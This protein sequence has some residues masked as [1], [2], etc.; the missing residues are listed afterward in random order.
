MSTKSRVLSGRRKIFSDYE[1]ITAENVVDML[2][3]ALLIHRVN[4]NEIDY[5]YKYYKGI[6]PVLERKKDVRPEICNKIIENHA[7]EIVS[8]K[9]GY[10]MGE[11]IQYISHGADDVSDEINALNE[12]VFAEDK[13]CKDRELADW[14]TICGTAFRMILPD[15]KNEMDESPFEIYTLD[16]RNT[17]VVYWSGLGNKAVAAVTFIEKQDNNVVYCVYTQGEYFEIENDIITK[18]TLHELEFIPIIEYPANEARL[19]AFEPVIP[20][21]DAI[22]EVESNRLDGVEQFIQAILLLKGTGIEDAQADE[23]LFSLGLKLPVDGDAKYLVQE[24]NQT[25]TQTLVDSMYQQV[26]IICGMPN[27]NG[28]SSTS[29]TGAAVIMRDGWEAAE[30]RAKSSE[31][32]FKKSEKEF[33]KIALKISNTFRDINLKLSQIEIRFTR[34]N[35]ENIS[36]KSSVLISM[37]SSDKIHPKLA[38]SHCGMFAD[39][40]SAYAMSEAYMREQEEKDEKDLEA[41]YKLQGNKNNPAEEEKNSENKEDVA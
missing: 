3:K 1:T 17:F 23:L 30:A 19:G 38:F 9:V 34:R 35:Y 29:D 31:T 22:N 28:G 25:Q 15:K 39:P 16:P 7:N 8:F 32:I 33:L 40:E 13:L 20:I 6:Q 11:P 18:H 36:A 37:L 41:F 5:L 10:L 4:A 24:L 26:L 12:F 21:L 27:R 14:F 2:N